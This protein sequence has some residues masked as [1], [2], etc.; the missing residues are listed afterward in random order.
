MQRL[1]NC[2]KVKTAELNSREQPATTLVLVLYNGDAFRFIVN[3]DSGIRINGSRILRH[4]KQIDDVATAARIKL[5]GIQSDRCDDADDVE[6]K[7]RRAIFLGL[8][9][10]LADGQIRQGDVDQVI[11]TAHTDSGAYAP[12]QEIEDFLLGGIQNQHLFTNRGDCALGYSGLNGSAPLMR[13]VIDLT[14][15]AADVESIELFS[16]GY[17]QMPQSPTIQSWEQAHE[18]VERL[19][20]HKVDAFANVKGSTSTEFADDRS[21]VVMRFG[22]AHSNGAQS[23]SP[24][25]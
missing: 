12:K 23:S 17:F 11:A 10:S 16:D 20:F 18:E 1:S 6:I 7:T 13:D 9:K 8:S 25:N 24:Q 2:L 14:L 15:P 5:F 22:N 3:G 19:D 4:Q 21:V